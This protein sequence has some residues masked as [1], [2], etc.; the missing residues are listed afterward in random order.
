VYVISFKLTL[1][2]V[3]NGRYGGTTDG[4]DPI[5]DAK[6]YMLDMFTLEWSWL[7]APSKQQA[8]F[9]ELPSQPAF[10]VGLWGH[11]ASALTLP[12]GTHA[13]LI[14]GGYSNVM[15]D[16]VLTYYIESDRWE[17]KSSE[18]L[19]NHP[20]F[21]MFALLPQARRLHSSTLVNRNGEDIL[22][23]FGTSDIEQFIKL[24]YCNRWIL[25]GGHRRVEHFATQ[26]SVLVHRLGY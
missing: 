23:F 7:D 15:S 1:F 3:T 18:D 25:K 14:Y 4:I 6:L 16:A 12:D 17:L 5:D 22:V 2:Q 21:E 8:D 26:L 9:N 11:S 13:I 19:V 10:A 20:D 24:R